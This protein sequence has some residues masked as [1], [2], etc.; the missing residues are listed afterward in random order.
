MVDIPEKEVMTSWKKC[1]KCGEIR[2]IRK[3]LREID[4]GVDFNKLIG[5]TMRF[6][7]NHNF[8]YGKLLSV[9]KDR[10][11]II[12]DDSIMGKTKIMLMTG[13]YV[14]QSMRG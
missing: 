6:E 10:K 8:F 1:I 11:Y 4:M 13:G 12:I 14:S 2:A 7:I 9:S 5:K 3:G